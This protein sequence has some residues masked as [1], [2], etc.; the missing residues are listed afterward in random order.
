MDKI[1][2]INLIERYKQSNPSFYL[3]LSFADTFMRAVVVLY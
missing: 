3:N 1:D 2:L